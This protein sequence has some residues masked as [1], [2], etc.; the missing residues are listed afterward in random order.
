MQPVP[1]VAPLT[2]EMDPRLK[3]WR[4][5]IFAATWLS[6]FAFYFCRRPFYVA[7]SSIEEHFAIDATILGYLGLAYLASYTIGQ[8][9]A[10]WAG[11]KWG[12]RLLLLTGMAGSVACNVVFGFTDSVWTFGAFLF[13]NGLAQA[14]G[15]SGNVGAMAPWFHRRE[16]GTVMGLW[17]TNFQVGGVVATALA[18]WVLGTYGFQWSFLTGSV[19]L[20]VVWVFFLFNQRNEPEDV[21]L[22]PVHSPVPED[23]LLEDATTEEVPADAL[24]EDDAPWTRDTKI[25]VAIV[26]TFYFF[27][28]FIRYAIW[29]WVPYMLYVSYG[30]DRA[31]A[32]YLSVAFDAAGILGVVTLGFLSDRYFSGRRAGISFLFMGGMAAACVLLF[33]L[34]P[35]SLVMFGVCL[36]LIGFTLYGPDAIM[37]SAGAIDV[38]SRKKATLAAGIINGMG[39]V[40]AMVQEVVLGRVLGDGDVAAVF[41]VLLLSSVLAAFCLGVLLLRNQQGRAAM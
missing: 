39:S 19:V 22:P 32:G 34:G 15:W 16:R 20:S 4:M 40:G 25:N 29:S 13:L 8:F 37:T 5:R 2:P 9:V 1:T 17:A 38:G 14:T 28:K 33:L 10:G 30:M 26:G 6:Y 36:A 41:S 27:V 23:D 11:N 7:K 31:E 35:T 3:S 12:P 24:D 21:G 18:S